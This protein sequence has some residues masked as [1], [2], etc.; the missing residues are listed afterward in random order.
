[1]RRPVTD[2]V[3][4]C[5]KRGNP[6]HNVAGLRPVNMRRNLVVRE[7]GEFV[8]PPFDR[9]DSDTGNAYGLDVSRESRACSHD[10][11]RNEPKRMYGNAESTPF[12]SHD[13]N[14]HADRSR[15][16]P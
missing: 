7:I 1:M 4:V 16:T 10:G 6:L 14:H 8:K 3:F 9:E 15:K 12:A 2:A 5:A 13:K 11:S